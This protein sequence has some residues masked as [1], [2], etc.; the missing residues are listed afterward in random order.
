[1]SETGAAGPTDGAVVHV[2][3]S[4]ELL[5]VLAELYGVPVDHIVA[6]NELIDDEIAAGQSH[7]DSLMQ[8]SVKI[9]H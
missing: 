4:G 7:M 5:V 6:F 3:A 9:P 1:M 2:V 8:G